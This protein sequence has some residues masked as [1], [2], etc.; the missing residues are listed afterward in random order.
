MKRVLI[1]DDEPSILTLLE[2]NLKQAAFEVET[3]EEGL[4][5]LDKILNESYDFILLDVML[6]GMDGMDICRKARQEGVETP[7][8][9]LTAKD[10]EYDKIVGLELGADDY[11]TKPFSPREVIARINAILR[12]VK[13]HDSNDEEKSIQYRQEA[14]DIELSEIERMQRD[15]DNEVEEESEQVIRL[16]KIEI[17]GDRYEVR[18]DG[19]II[20]ITPKEFELL[21]Y[22]ALRKG[23]ILSRERLLNSVW[24]FDYAGETRI[25]D[26]HISHLR[27]KIEEN[28]KNPKYIK[29][30]RG[31][32]YRFE[33][34][35]E[36]ESL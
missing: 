17:Y 23:R 27:E 16:G 1:V 26:V 20:D 28:T 9:M 11:M 8:L 2:Y 24:D 13:A 6:P 21:V 32:G 31:F 14:T 36:D 34:P 30:V 4:D 3:C 33:V 12:R 22:M 19:E 25:V 10:E 5:A 35:D 7:I 18:V 29:T 15:L